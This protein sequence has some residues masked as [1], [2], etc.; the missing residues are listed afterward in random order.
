MTGQPKLGD[1]RYIRHVLSPTFP[2]PV[3]SQRDDVLDIEEWD[4]EAWRNIGK[5]TRSE[6][7]DPVD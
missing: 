5:I 4:G 2:A 6:L 1:R 7:P 3:D